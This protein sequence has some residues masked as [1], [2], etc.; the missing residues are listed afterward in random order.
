VVQLLQARLL[1]YQGEEGR[2]RE[3]IEAVR[4]QQAR[5]TTAG[6]N[7][8]AMA[9][10]EEVLWSMIDLATRDASDEEWDALEERSAR[11]SVGQE[12][13]EVIE[14]RARARARR[15]RH[16]EAKAALARAIETAGRIPNMMQERLARQRGA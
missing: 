7:D 14:A 15:G 13:I 9:P 16:E 3:I 6:R 8:T 10:A 2:A 5:A 11:H 1:L 12:Q 4:D